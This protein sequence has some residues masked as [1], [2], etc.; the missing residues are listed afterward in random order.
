MSRLLNP[1]VRGITAAVNAARTFAPVPSGP[2]VPGLPLSAIRNPAVPTTSRTTVTTTVIRVSTDQAPGVR[3]SLASSK[4]TGKPS[5]P[6][7]TA[8][9]MV[10][11]IHGSATYCI[12]LSALSPNPALLNDEIAWNTPEYA[13]DGSDWP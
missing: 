8:A 9:Q 3:H 6:T 5:P 1:A 7:M 4:T 10:R 2:R 13:A 12:R 11:L